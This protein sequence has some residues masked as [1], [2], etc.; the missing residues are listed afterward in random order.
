MTLKKMAGKK[1]QKWSLKIEAM[2]KMKFDDGI[3][4][5][6]GTMEW[7]SLHNSWDSKN[8][9]ENVYTKSKCLD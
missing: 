8:S 1:T 9:W 5:A 3:R 6:W 2:A 4:N 7:S